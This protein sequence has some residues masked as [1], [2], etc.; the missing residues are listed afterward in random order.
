MLQNAHSE[1]RRTKIKDLCDQLM[2]KLAERENEV[3]VL[4]HC[5]VIGNIRT[6]FVQSAGCQ[7]RPTCR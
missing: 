5:R 4:A 7:P 1:E 2:G 6:D 3:P